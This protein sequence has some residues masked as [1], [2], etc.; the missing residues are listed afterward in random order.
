MTS[1]KRKQPSFELLKKEIE[2]TPKDWRPNASS[3][4]RLAIRITLILVYQGRDQTAAD[5]AIHGQS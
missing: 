5:A 2:Q 4:M 1:T 3:R